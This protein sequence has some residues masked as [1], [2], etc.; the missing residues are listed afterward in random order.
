MFRALMLTAAMSLVSAPALAGPD[1]PVP[2]TVRV[3]D[4]TGT[5][6]PTATV[7]HPEERLRHPVNVE[8]GE[9]SESVL[10]LESG[11]EIR[12]LK[13]Q[14]LELEISASGFENQTVRYVIRRRRNLIP[15]ILQPMTVELGEDEDDVVIQFRRDKPIE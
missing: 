13:D 15:V 10:Y 11:K 12:F 6:I 7:R 8:T 1:D 2:V 5:P 3:L 9:W 14:A 4:P